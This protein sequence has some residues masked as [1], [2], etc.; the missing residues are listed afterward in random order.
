MRH[1]RQQAAAICELV[2]LRSCLSR[3]YYFGFPEIPTS[4]IVQP[5]QKE[6]KVIGSMT[7]KNWVRFKT[8]FQHSK[9]LQPHHL[10]GTALRSLGFTLSFLWSFGY[11]ARTPTKY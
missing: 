8:E 1:P 7:D 5:Q 11:F 10:A 3:N 9:H 2:Y 4:S 6:L